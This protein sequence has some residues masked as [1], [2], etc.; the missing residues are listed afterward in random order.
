VRE[1]PRIVLSDHAVERYQ[2]RVKPALDLQA[3]REDLERMLPLGTF[4]HD[5]P[6]WDR[7]FDE[8]DGWLLLG[9]GIVIPLSR[10][11][12]RRPG[13]WAITVLSHR[14]ISPEKRRARNDHKARQRQARA[15]KRKKW[16]EHKQT[17]HRAATA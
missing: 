4:Q 14:E 15:M 7:P 9:E 3:A 5:P 10:N 2:E 8:A 11:Q 17:R 12:D 16:I 1:T 13:F 6:P